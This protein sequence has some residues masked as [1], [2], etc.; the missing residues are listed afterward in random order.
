M[1]AWEFNYTLEQNFNRNYLQN[2]SAIYKF[3]IQNNNEKKSSI[4]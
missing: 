4:R 2:V 3:T 1:A